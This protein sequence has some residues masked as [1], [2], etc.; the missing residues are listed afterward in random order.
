MDTYAAFPQLRASDNLKKNL[1]A[2]ND[3]SL[4]TRVRAAKSIEHDLSTFVAAAMWR[5]QVQREA[6]QRLRADVSETQVRLAREALNLN[7]AI[8]KYNED[9]RDSS[10][11]RYASRLGF[12]PI[13]DRLTVGNAVP[14]EG[15]GMRPM[16]PNNQALAPAAKPKSETR[17]AGDATSA[18]RDRLSCW[19][20]N[21]GILAQSESF[22]VPAHGDVARNS[23]RLNPSP[24]RDRWGAQCSSRMKGA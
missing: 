22:L 24:A 7:A 9:I 12:F 4:A 14:A 3:P 5:S 16:H 6:L 17:E 15:G 21:W 2:L 10:N 11:R 23:N 20:G 13:I 8:E 18:K 1:N 19:R